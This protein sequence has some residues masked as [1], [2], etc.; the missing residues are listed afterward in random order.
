[1]TVSKNAY[2]T[3]DKTNKAILK[4]KTPAGQAW[5]HVTLVLA[6]RKLYDSKDSLVYI[7]NPRP[8]KA[9]KLDPVSKIK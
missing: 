3:R 4:F 1:M 8:A 6:L 5:W 7:K 2:Q 9:R